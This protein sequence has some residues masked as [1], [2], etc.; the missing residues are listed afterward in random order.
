MDGDVGRRSLMTMLV[1]E[2]WT[3]TM[4]GYGVFITTMK[5]DIEVGRRFWTT[6]E[7]DD[8]GGRWSTCLSHRAVHSGDCL[9]LF[10]ACLAF[11]LSRWLLAERSSGM[12]SVKVHEWC[13]VC[14]GWL[15]VCLRSNFHAGLPLQ[16]CYKPCLAC[17]IRWVSCVAYLIDGIVCPYKLPFVTR[18]LRRDTN[19]EAT[20]VVQPVAA[21]ASIAWPMKC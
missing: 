15:D 19:N 11:W 17:S 12:I 5:F 21:H 3:T 8:E 20:F 6:M 2:S 1:N 13:L 16:L 14:Y 4:F 9:L 18:C 10:G 7:D